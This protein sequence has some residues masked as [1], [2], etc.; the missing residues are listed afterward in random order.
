MSNE[1]VVTLESRHKDIGLKDL[2]ADEINDHMN[3]IH[4]SLCGS[5]YVILEL[6]SLIRDVLLFPSHS[7][8]SPEI[9][10]IC[11]RNGQKMKEV[12]LGVLEDEPGAKTLPAKQ[13]WKIDEK[14]AKFVKIPTDGLR[15][16]R[17]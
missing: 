6:N 11:E 5:E 8:S 7:K 3:T 13:A 12:V 14:N 17:D 1:P 9:N 16:S 2:G 10:G 4:W 15:C